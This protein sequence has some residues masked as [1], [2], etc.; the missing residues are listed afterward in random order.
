MTGGKSR[1]KKD[2]GI[3]VCAGQLV[4]NGEILARGLD[5]YKAGKNV[6]G[7][8]TLYALCSGRVGFLKKKTPQGKVR[9]F[10]NVLPIV[11]PPKESKI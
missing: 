11:Q 1:P 7:W 3:K 6:R 10:I 5:I 8:D 4:K 9:T 2:K